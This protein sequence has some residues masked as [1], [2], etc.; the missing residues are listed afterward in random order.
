ME[1]VGAVNSVEADVGVHNIHTI[2][3]AAHIDVEVLDA[4]HVRL[5]RVV[6]SRT[7]CIC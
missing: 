7:N 6:R 3:S 1:A 4:N 5:R 2:S